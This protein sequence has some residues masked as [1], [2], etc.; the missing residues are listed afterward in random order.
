MKKTARILSVV[1]LVVML[2]TMLASCST[3]TGE[4]QASA[5]GVTT[6]YKFGLFGSVTITTEASILGAVTKTEIEG[7]YK[8]EDDQITFT[9]D[10]EDEEE[11]KEYSGTFTFEKLEDG[12]KI[13]LITYQKV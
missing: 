10:S 7:K 13:G 3:F 6:T 11:A 12:I 8:V 5:L 1:L 4:Y 2:C 9:F